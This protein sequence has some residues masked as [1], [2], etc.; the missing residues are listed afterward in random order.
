MCKKPHF[1]PHHTK[2]GLLREKRF[3]NLLLLLIALA[4]PMLASVETQSGTCGGSMTTAA[5]HSGNKYR[6]QGINS[7]G[8]LYSSTVT[9]TVNE[10]GR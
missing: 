5:R 2:G 1:I 6:C 4:Q 10:Y 8:S 3:P 7:V 9:L